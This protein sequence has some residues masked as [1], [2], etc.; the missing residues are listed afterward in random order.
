MYRLLTVPDN[1]HPLYKQT[2]NA[3]KKKGMI[4]FAK[5]HSLQEINPWP[6]GLII[7]P[8]FEQS[9]LALCLDGH[10]RRIAASYTNQ[11]YPIL[12]LEN[13]FDYNTYFSQEESVESLDK[14]ILTWL[15]R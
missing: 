12:I 5:K 11:Q 15:S 9:E 13:V 14:K 8:P 6:I 10:S 1:I 7:P 2:L 3:V 4:A